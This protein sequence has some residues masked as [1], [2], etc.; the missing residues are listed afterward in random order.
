VWTYDDQLD[1]DGA[2]SGPITIRC[3][4]RIGDDGVEVDLTG[5]DA[6]T[7]GGVNAVAAVAYSAACFVLRCLMPADVPVNEGC[8][9]RLRVIAPEGTVVN[10]RPPAAVGA[11]N[12]ECSQRICDA[13]FGAFALAAPDL[14]PAAS[15]GTMNNVLVGGVDSAGRPFS[16]YETIAGG[17]GGAP[18]GPGASG[19]H[20]NMTNTRNTPIEALEHAYPFRAAVYELRD[21]SGG[22]GA[23][24]GGDGVVR[25]FEVLAPSAVVTL[26]TERRTRGPWGLA[27][28]SDGTPGRNFIDGEA[29]P[30]KIVRYVDNGARVRVET[31]GGGGWGTPTREAD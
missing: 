15:Q 11:G 8:W 24:P 7:R 22:A 20:T 2:G 28:G 26:M 1:D 6:Q 10:A 3:T 23:N 21:G 30:G 29:V 13:I 5:S 31:P 12:V 4:L 17:A 25:E 14:V 9:R 16:Y 18:W 19:V 27:G